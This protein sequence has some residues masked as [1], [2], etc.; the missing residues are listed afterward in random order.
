MD[1]LNGNHQSVGPLNDNTTAAA[2]DDHC[3]DD[4]HQRPQSPPH[5]ELSADTTDNSDCIDDRKDETSV[6]TTDAS[7]VAPEDGQQ[8]NKTLNFGKKRL[9]GRQKTTSAGDFKGSNGDIQVVNNGGAGGSLSSHTRKSQ[10]SAVSSHKWPQI[11]TSSSSNVL[12]S[13][14]SSHSISGNSNG[15]NGNNKTTNGVNGGASEDR[16]L[17]EGIQFGA[18]L[19]GHEFVAEA[20]GE[21]MC[22]QSLKKLKVS[23]HSF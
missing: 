8:M 6:T 21:H 15:M 16:F 4:D 13:T 1:V 10:S 22:Q 17:G 18:K 7:S 20:R 12:S 19:I 14:A 5:P 2:V 23:Y 9:F 3:L 11:I